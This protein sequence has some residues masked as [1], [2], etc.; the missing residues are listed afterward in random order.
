MF[1]HTFTVDF[2]IQLGVLIACF[3]AWAAAGFPRFTEVVGFGGLGFAC[4][5]VFI[6][7]TWNKE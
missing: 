7:L 3:G 4:V 6:A 5:G 2:F 1:K